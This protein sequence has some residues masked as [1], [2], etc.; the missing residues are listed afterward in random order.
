MQRLYH[1]DKKKYMTKKD[2]IKLVTKDSN[3]AISDRDAIYCY[4]MSKMTVEHEVKESKKYD[5]LELVEFAEMV[6]RIAD[7]K[8]KDQLVFDLGEK[9][10]LILDDLFALLP[11]YKRNEK[12]KFDEE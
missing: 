4:G 7:I 8:Y 9:I 6:G 1:T 5:R 3:V 11:D 10:E 2:A 12:A